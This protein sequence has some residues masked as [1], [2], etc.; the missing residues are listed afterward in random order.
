V[1]AVASLGAAAVMA[2]SDAGDARHG[3]GPTASNDI[4]GGV[5]AKGHGLDAVGAIVA[6]DATTTVDFCNGTLIAPKLVLTSKRCAIQ[7]D[8]VTP[9][10][11]APTQVRTVLVEKYPLYFI[12]GA[13]IASPSHKVRIESVDVCTTPDTGGMDGFGC[14]VAVYR[15]TEAIADITPLPFTDKALG[16]ELV[17]QRFSTV[18]YGDISQDLTKQTLG[19]RHAGT[20]TL[21]SVAGAPMKVLFPTEADFVAAWT[22]AEGQASAQQLSAALATYYETTLQPDLEAWLGGSDGDAQNCL[23]DQGSPLLAKNAEG[24]LTVFGIASNSLGGSHTKCIPFGAPYAMLGTAAQ[25]LISKNLVDPCDAE[26]AAGRCDGDIAVRCTT[27]AE[28]DRRITRS[29]CSA[30]LQHCVAPSATNPQVACAD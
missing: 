19:Q 2:C 1:A 17:G 3:D 13:A 21:R 10:G 24:K 8:N 15:L 6:A 28:G 27:P 9:D 5:D 7:Y 4:I 16:P 14:N 25:A 23:D 12:T 11:G 22:K 20:L 26:T 29:D 30:V 18:G